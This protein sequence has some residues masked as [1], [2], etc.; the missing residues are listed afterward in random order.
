MLANR[1]GGGGGDG[2]GSNNEMG[3]GP[4]D[5]LHAETRK[6]GQQGDWGHGCR[7]FSFMGIGYEECSPFIIPHPLAQEMRENQLYTGVYKGAERLDQ[8][9]RREQAAG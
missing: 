4:G 9:A 7:L 3:L 8:D 2:S 1:T 5:L 6:I